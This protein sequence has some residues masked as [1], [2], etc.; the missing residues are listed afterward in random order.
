MA[1]SQATRREL[2]SRVLRRERPGRFVYAPNYWQWFTHFSNHGL[3][4]A[5]LRGCGSQLEL[6]RHLGLDVFSRNIYCDPTLCWFG[7]L[8]EEVLSGVELEVARHTDGRDIVTERTY[9]TS[10]GTLTERLR[11]IFSESTLVQEKFLLEDF[12][13][14]A[15]AF[16]ALLEGRR[17]RFNRALFEHWQ[18]AVGDDGVVNAGELFSPLK[19]LHMAASVINAVY[20]IE[21]HPER[22]AAWM[23][24]HEEAQLDLVR[25]MLDGGVTAMIAMDNLDSAFHPPRYLEL[26]SASF[27]E[28][29]ATAC[30]AAGAV[31]LI[32]ACGHQRAILPLVGGLGVDGLEGVAFPSLGDVELDEAMQLGG[33]RLIIT[34]G[35]S[36]METEGFKTRDEV[37]RYVEDLLRRLEPY[38]H[39]FMLSAS[40]S[41]SILTPWIVIEWFRDAWLE[42]RGG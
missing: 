4:P 28:R 7:G 32:H 6:I 13:R 42:F 9:R 34:G 38:R 19:L 10:R 39:R 40:C 15:D 27:Y 2:V 16:E 33:E 36:A 18:R 3:L 17:W 25:E 29:A 22:C 20:I 21:D 11:Y 35:I 1:N 31:F 14:E 5:E 12:E 26:C 23:R 41:T 30:R 37:R 8:A 24:A